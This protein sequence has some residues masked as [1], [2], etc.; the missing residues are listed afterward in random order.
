MTRYLAPYPK[1]I[2]I[3]SILFLLSSCASTS[4]FRPYP[5][6]IN[7][8]ITDIKAD[9]DPED[10]LDRLNTYRDRKDK[11]LY[12]M[13]R[14]RVAQIYGETDTSVID[15]GDAIRFVREFE[16]KALISASSWSA[17]G[18]S[19]IT[20]DN[21]IPY[22][23]EGYEKVML[24]H[25]Q[26]A[27]Y[28]FRGDIEGAGVEVRRANLEQTNALRQH[29]KDIVAAESEAENKHAHFTENDE[30][31]AKAYTEMD[32]LIGE[33]KSSFQN[34][35]TFYFSGI[36][37]ELLKSPNDAYIDYK[38]ALEIYPD[39]RYL[40]QD[41]LRLAKSLGFSDEYEKYNAQFGPYTPAPETHNS[42][43]V[44][45]FE[46]GFAPQKT[47][48]KIPF[49]INNRLISIA[50][51][52]Y[53]A[54]PQRVGQLQLLENGQS[55]GHSSII[56]NMQALAAKALSESRTILTI[57]QI[58][59]VLVKAVALDNDSQNLNIIASIYNLVSENADLRSWLTLPAEAH[60]LRISLPAGEKTFTFKHTLSNS[61]K[62]IHL[63][64][65]ENSLTVVRV[66]GAG[67]TL[68]T[69]SVIFP[70]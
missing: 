30:R 35:Y 3:T 36:V 60:I 47:Q 14:G 40:Q 51:P 69:E 68:Y 10:A 63:N 28:L 66:V 62:T 1:I 13:E 50:F 61:E 17:Q 15:Y 56:V 53:K 38:K 6:Q 37:Y 59:R 8:I 21:V 55:L 25:F 29:Q 46:G 33:V 9:E 5:K 70:R 22:E 45:F 34:A 4:L 31:V 67:Q 27:N 2:A 32:P 65:P 43:L 7:P 23:G 41:T 11:V 44:V 64:L 16:Q 19:L 39:N 24:Y 12:L 49:I 58:L 18:F 54:T 48:I 52:I 20:N 57:R 42:E 26:G